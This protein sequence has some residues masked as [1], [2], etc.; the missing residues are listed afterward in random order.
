VAEEVWELD[1]PAEWRVEINSWQWDILGL[2]TIDIGGILL[3]VIDWFLDRINGV[4]AWVMDAL[5]NAVAAWNWI[6]AELRREW[7]EFIDLINWMLGWMAAWLDRLDTWFQTKIPSIEEIVN[8]LLTPFG[9][10]LDDIKDWLA[11]LV[12]TWDN[13]WTNTLPTLV[14][15][16]QVDDLIRT[17]LRP[18]LDLIAPLVDFTEDIK[19][20]F[21]DPW[22][23]LY[24]L[25]DD[26]IERFW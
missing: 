6:L 17:A 21:V 26:F 19:L 1:I 25:L 13:F 8:T 11:Q 15:R 16:F 20:F 23:F 24:N 3:G 2:F 7:D 10:D 9:I 5:D 14:N 4:I 12:A 22:Q 18:V